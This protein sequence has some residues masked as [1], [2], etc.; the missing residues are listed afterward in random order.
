MMSTPM[1]EIFSGTH[2]DELVPLTDDEKLGHLR[3]FHKCINT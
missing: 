3:V 2:C 1:E